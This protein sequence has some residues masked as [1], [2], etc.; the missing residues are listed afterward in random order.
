MG[1]VI[2]YLVLATDT[3]LLPFWLFIAAISTD[4]VDGWVARKLGATSRLGLFLDPMADKTLNGCTWLCTAFAGWC[5]WWLAGL[6]LFRTFVVTMFWVFGRQG[7][8]PRPTLPGRLMVTFEG[9][10]LPVLLFR[11]SWFDVH[12]NSVG[13]VIGGIS[14]AFAVMSAIALILQV[15]SAPSRRA[16]PSPR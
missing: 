6:M 2:A 5:P 4:L 13:I 11:V 3:G 14:L 7:S 8:A 12:W 16:T 1:P 10:A 9:I 15:R